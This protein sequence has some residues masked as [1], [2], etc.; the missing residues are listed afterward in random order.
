MLPG[1]P[2][3][4]VRAGS[5][6]LR[7]KRDLDDQA[8]EDAALDEPAPPRTGFRAR[9]LV[10]AE[11]ASVGALCRHPKLLTG[12]WLGEVPAGQRAGYASPVTALWENGAIA[13]AG[14]LR[15]RAVSAR[16]VIAAHIGR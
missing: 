3:P 5:W 11:A 8:A 6:R 16:E 9:L 2:S 4:P 15:R 13:L 10:K 12:R 7:A 1:R 14:M